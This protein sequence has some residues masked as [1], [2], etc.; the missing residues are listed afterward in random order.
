MKL[1]FILSTTFNI[2][3]MRYHKSYRISYRRK[4][5]DPFPHLFLI[6]FALVM[7]LLVHLDWTLWE[8]SWSISLLLESV[9]VLP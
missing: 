3:L 8:L 2:Y 9:A 5:E 7:T 4:E 1:L 6:P